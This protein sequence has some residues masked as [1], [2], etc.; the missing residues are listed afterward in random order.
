MEKIIAMLR[1]KKIEDLLAIFASLTVIIFSLRS[2]IIIG[3][4]YLNLFILVFG[5]AQLFMTLKKL[6]FGFLIAACEFFIFGVIAF[7][8]IAITLPD[9]RGDLLDATPYFF[10]WILAI[11]LFLIACYFSSL[12]LKARKC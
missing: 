10:R 6:R 8:S 4:N 2:C 7:F 1:N 3:L 9:S 12:L 11:T 5:A